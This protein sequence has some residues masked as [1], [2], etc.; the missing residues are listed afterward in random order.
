[1]SLVGSPI[2]TES[3]RVHKNASAG[4]GRSVR[5]HIRVDAR[6]LRGW[7]RGAF[8]A[9]HTVRTHASY[10]R[11]SPCVFVRLSPAFPPIRPSCS[12]SL[13]LSEGARLRLS[14]NQCHPS[15]ERRAVATSSPLSPSPSLPRVRAPAERSPAVLKPPSVRL[16]TSGVGY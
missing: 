13:F 6:V 11:S 2:G 16:G 8:H 10:A 15:V 1:M 12:F 5:G 14:T 7:E 9:M 4:E 3:L